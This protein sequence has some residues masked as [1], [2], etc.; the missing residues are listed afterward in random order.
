M[1]RKRDRRPCVKLFLLKLVYYA[2]VMRDIE[3]IEGRGE[4]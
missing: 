4:V 2:L 3:E 1:L